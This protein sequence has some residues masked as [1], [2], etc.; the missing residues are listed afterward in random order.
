MRAL[1]RLVDEAD[2]SSTT[3]AGGGESLGLTG[4]TLRTSNPRLI[5][6]SVARSATTG[7]SAANRPYEIPGQA[8]PGS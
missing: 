3:C 4:E 8:S 7:R 5:Y 2:V 1:R 6:C